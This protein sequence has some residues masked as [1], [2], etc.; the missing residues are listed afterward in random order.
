MKELPEEM[1]DWYFPFNWKVSD[2]WDLKGEIEVRS[3]KDLEWH[4]DIPFW[5][6]ERGKG[7]TFDLKP[8][9]VLQ[10]REI[11][12]YHHKR[13]LDTDESYPLCVTSYKGKEIIIDGI[14]RL[15]KLKIKKAKSITVEVFGEHAIQSIA[16]SA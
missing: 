13:I 3:L 9:D 7:M 11:N 8:R 6:S 2:I 4:L 12:N 1:K 10:N 14:H 15:A 5:S 16:I